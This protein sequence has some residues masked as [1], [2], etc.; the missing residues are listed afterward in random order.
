MVALKQDKGIAFQVWMLYIQNQFKIKCHQE[1]LSSK[2][3]GQDSSLN[4]YQQPCAIP[5]PLQHHCNS[6]LFFSSY[7]SASLIL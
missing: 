4:V 6:C 5:G 7:D 3:H 2:T 1:H